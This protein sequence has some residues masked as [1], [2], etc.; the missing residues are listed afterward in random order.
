MSQTGVIRCTA[1]SGSTAYTGSYGFKALPQ[2]FLQ[3]V[4]RLI[5]VYSHRPRLLC[6]SGKEL[7]CQK[8]NIKGDWAIVVT[9]GS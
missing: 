5:S 6:A 9:A 8:K 7:L 2:L 4:F 3:A 1:G